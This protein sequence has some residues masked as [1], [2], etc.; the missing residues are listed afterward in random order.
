MLLLVMVFQSHE[1]ENCRLILSNSTEQK[2]SCFYFVG[3]ILTEEP[4]YI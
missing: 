3:V 2:K 1:K 4:D